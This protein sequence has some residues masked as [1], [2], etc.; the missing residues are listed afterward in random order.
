MKSRLLLIFLLLLSSVAV[1][2]VILPGSAATG[3]ISHPYNLTL[4]SQSFTLDGSQSYVYMRFYGNSNMLYNFT[5]NGLHDYSASFYTNSSSSYNNYLQS[6]YI[7]ASIPGSVSVFG[8]SNYTIRVSTYY[9]A[10]P[11]DIKIAELAIP[12]GA[13]PT[14]AKTA[15]LG[16]NS[17]QLLYTSL[18]IYYKL[19]TTIGQWYDMSL[20]PSNLYSRVGLHENSTGYYEGGSSSYYSSIVSTSFKAT[21]TTTYLQLDTDTPTNFVLSI[22]TVGTPPHSALST[23]MQANLGKNSGEIYQ[24]NVNFYFNLTTQVD[25]WYEVVPTLPADT[26][27]SISYSQFP[28][29]QSVSFWSGVYPFAFKA[30]HTTTTFTIDGNGDTGKFDLTINKISA[31]PHSSY[32]DPQIASLGSNNGEIQYR[33]QPYYLNLTTTIGQWY[34]L[35]LQTPSHSDF[36]INYQTLSSWGGKTTQ[37]SNIESNPQLTAFRAYYTYNVIYIKAYNTT[38]G[39]FT[40]NIKK[41][42]AI[43]HTSMQDAQNAVVGQNT[44]STLYQDIPYV[45]NLTTIPGH[46]YTIN[47]TG[48]ASSEMSVQVSS[49]L[50]NPS[51]YFYNPSFEAFKAVDT[52][53]QISATTPDQAGTFNINIKEYSNVPYDTAT[54]ATSF[55]LGSNSGTTPD[56]SIPL[57]FTLS[58]KKGQWYQFNT[59]I[60]D[61]GKENDYDLKVVYGPDFYSPTIGLVGLD[62]LRGDGSTVIIQVMSSAVVGSFNVNIAEVNPTNYNFDT[63]ATASEGSHAYSFQYGALPQYYHFTADPNSYYQVQIKTDNPLQ[64]KFLEAYYENQSYADYVINTGSSLIITGQSNYYFSVQMDES[65]QFT[66]SITKIN[67]PKSLIFGQLQAGDTINWQV[68]THISQEFQDILDFLSFSI[69]NGSFSLT[70]NDNLPHIDRLGVYWGD[71]VFNSSSFTLS[72]LNNEFYPIV[73]LLLPT[74]VNNNAN[75]ISLPEY[76]T[77]SGFFGSNIQIT[78]DST[79]YHITSELNYLIPFT[80]EWTFDKATGILL[81]QTVSFVAQGYNFYTQ[82]VIFQSSSLFTNSSSTDSSSTNTPTIQTT[83]NT[84]KPSLLDWQFWSFM[85]GIMVLP[86]IVKRRR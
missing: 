1:S 8:Y 3:D 48:P 76:I 54:T 9:S 13:T 34:E 16:D 31:V 68:T 22:S 17:G 35:E 27:F 21:Q 77:N 7:Q 67:Y 6:L 72:N 23:A 83:S 30:D 32:S 25:Q 11:I 44:G 39:S 79:Q 51:S 75:P 40:L 64:F 71:E 66:L 46:W 70:S 86:V 45:Y 49:E 74:E 20:T 18:P 24:N 36:S 10:G 65:L 59:T 33:N 62:Y 61:A 58:T 81:N 14:T 43:D 42:N 5:F 4:G 57:Y 80:G 52:V 55:A 82:S 47:G 15:L 85:L 78:E 69:D 53:Y 84:G 38:M 50:Q 12:T 41:I 26:S 2:Y 56:A 60:T 29:D 63:A 73:R 37:S 28:Y 19:T